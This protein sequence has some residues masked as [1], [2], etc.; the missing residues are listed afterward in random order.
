MRFFGVC[1][2]WLLLAG[3]AMAAET[4]RDAAK[5]AS[6]ASPA[7]NDSRPSAEA[8]FSDPA[9]SNAVL[10][11]NGRY[12]AYVVKTKDFN[13]ILVDDLTSNT[14]AIAV[15][16]SDKDNTFDW[17]KWKSDSRLIAGVTHLQTFYF[18]QK[19]PDSGILSWKYAKYMVAVD[20]DGAN[21]IVL[22]KS[23][24]HTA[25]KTNYV[26]ELL[27]SL[28]SDPDHVLA[29][30]PTEAGDVAVWKVDVHTGAA[31]VIERG[32]DDILQW[33]TDRTGTIVARYRSW[34]GTLTIEGRSPGGLK[35]TPIVK[36]REKTIN[37]ELADFDFL[38]GAEAPGT[39]YV[40]VKPKTPAEGDVRSI[41]IYDFRT[42]TLGPAIWPSTAYDVSSIVTSLKTGALVGVCYWIDTLQCDYKDAK[43]QAT[44]R[45]IAA[46]FDHRRNIDP[47]SWS[48]DARWMLLYVSGPDDP[49]SYYLYDNEKHELV[50]LGDQRPDLPAERLGQM[51][52]FTFTTHDGLKI[53]GYL[54]RPAGAPGGPLPL[55]VIPHGGP[56]DR[57]ALDYDTWAQFIATR[58]YMVYQPN[59]RGSSGYGVRWL[60]AGFGEW[61][62]KMQDDVF[63]GVKALIAD[64]QA[65]PSRVCVFGGSYGGYTALMQGA[66]HPDLYKCVV[67]WAG[68]SDLP[69]MLRAD[70]HADGFSDESYK[71]ELKEIGNPD[72]DM[73]KLLRASAVT[74][75]Q[76]YGPPV[77]LVHG[78]DD[79]RVDIDQSQEM[80][81]ALKKARRDARL[82]TVKDEGHTDWTYDHMKKT[83]SQV[84]DFIA[85]HI[86]PAPLATA[87]P[88]PAK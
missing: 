15:R 26:M 81:H 10:S 9:L 77:L 42:N 2:I 5:P 71:Y 72:T 66:Q 28:R 60:E 37:K 16:N 7:T 33:E 21:L 38:G 24:R 32:E 67:S 80:E 52:T 48:D 41:H 65:D 85:A 3:P 47:V 73:A 56:M 58:G 22:F 17:I 51:Q 69:K 88:S 70:R 25:H 64:G 75:A 46:Y 74:Y 1:A 35:W 61:G 78:D 53:P 27:D 50:E 11:P 83:M 14:R 19:N 13:G 34:A 59:F 68:I 43:K 39:L 12:L 79:G 20:R 55:V 86:A 40:A 87:P 23:D 54:T 84:A 62:G 18:D 30:A 49:G 63:E 31:T 36:L 4:S 44:M 82:I 76:D 29:E 8:F 57:D 6:T 45:G